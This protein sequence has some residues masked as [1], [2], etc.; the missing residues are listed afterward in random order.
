[1]FRYELDI[2]I[3]LDMK[4]LRESAFLLFLLFVVA[5]PSVI[6]QQIHQLYQERYSQALK[7]YEEER[8]IVAIDMLEELLE[9]PVDSSEPWIV[10]T[11]GYAALHDFKN[12]LNTLDRAIKLFPET[13]PLFQLKSQIYFETGEYEKA[14]STMYRVSELLKKDGDNYADLSINN[15][16]V[17]SLNAHLGS[18][19]VQNNKLESAA[20]F[21][22]EAIRLEPDSLYHHTNLIF[23]LAESGQIHEALEVTDRAIQRFS[24]NSD[25]LKIKAALISRTDDLTSLE[26]IL[27]AII[28]EEPDNTEIAANY[29][30]VLLNNQNFAEANRITEEILLNKNLG[31]TR[32]IHLAEAFENAGFTA[33]Q[34]GIWRQYLIE[35]PDDHEVW[36]KKAGLLH[37]TGE[38]EE[39]EIIY[40]RLAETGDGLQAKKLLAALYIDM[41]RVERA[42]EMYTT[43]TEQYPEKRDLHWSRASLLME[44]QL[45]DEAIEPLETILGLQEDNKYW[46]E[47]AN[48]LMQ[49][50]YRDEALRVYQALVEEG[51]YHPTI[52]LELAR[53][54]LEIPGLGSGCEMK[55]SAMKLVLRQIVSEQQSLL[56][57]LQEGVFEPLNDRQPGEVN[58]RQLEEITDAFLELILFGCDSDQALHFIEELIHLYGNSGNIQL[59]TASFFDRLGE[60]ERALSHALLAVELSPNSIDT[61]MMHATLLAKINQ[62]DEAAQAYEKILALDPYHEEAYAALLRIYRNTNRMDELCDRWMVRYQTDRNNEVLKTYLNE[63]LIR[64]GRWAD[65][66]KL[67]NNETGESVN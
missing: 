33:G 46:Y 4:L 27:A 57:T 45:W 65:A 26:Q 59:L 66:Q 42:V 44:M 17:A 18:I 3:R 47:W 10:L 61:H 12:A 36:F 22:K 39:A 43:L 29:V 24:A 53:G 63:A 1:M 40:K 20:D 67:R 50:G 8:Y 60:K 37:Q 7:A 35:F 48:T 2:Q 25:L 31:S 28:R 13:I 38:M 58:L 34:I 14:L 41:D 9:F 52:F 49:A 15:A 6:G 5:A 16:R 11:S 51:Y 19:E 23:A 54:D 30:W 56:L 32:Y 62:S 64:A 21:F 55:Q